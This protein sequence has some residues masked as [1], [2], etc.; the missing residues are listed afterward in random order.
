M[1]PIRLITVIGITL[2]ALSFLL[3]KNPFAKKKGDKKEKTSIARNSED[4]VILK[5]SD[6]YNLLP[7]AKNTVLVVP[8]SGCW[9][10]WQV[11]DTRI[12]YLRVDPEREIWIQNSFTDGT[13]GDPH[14][15]NPKRDVEIKKTVAA[16]RF[17][18]ESETPIKVTVTQQ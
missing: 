1:K 11:R 4:E 7:A 14:L 17:K 5:C 2:A 16:F 8:P 15:D 13:A 3:F 6:A 9:T 18:N 12:R 10:E